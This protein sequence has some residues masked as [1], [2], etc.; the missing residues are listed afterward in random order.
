MLQ[1][2][3][4]LMHAVYVFSY[5]VNDCAVS[6]RD[7]PSGGQLGLALD[8]KTIQGYGHGPAREFVVRRM[9]NKD[10]NVPKIHKKYASPRG[11]TQ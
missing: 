8:V 11:A 2:P 4:N 1:L 3:E 6:L 5:D 10:S 7:K 9:T